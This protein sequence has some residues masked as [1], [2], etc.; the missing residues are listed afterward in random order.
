LS[1]IAVIYTTFLRDDLAK[2]TLKSILNNWNSDYKL[3][4]G[5]QSGGKSNGELFRYF[6]DYLQKNKK[7]KCVSYY[8]LPF[9]CG[10]S[11]ARNF[12]VKK[13]QELGC[14]YCLVTADSI[15]FTKKY[16]FDSIIKFMELKEGIV[17]VGF[18]L[19]NRVPWEFNMR[20]LPGECF[21][22]RLSSEKFLK[23]LGIEYQ[24]VDICKNFFLAKTQLLLNIP[25]DNEL[26]L[27]EH[28]DH[29]WRLKQVGYKTYVTNSINAEYIDDKPLEYKQYRNR[30]YLEYR[31]K[32]QQKYDI[33][34]WVKR[35]F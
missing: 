19:K 12:L 14:G 17:K 23:Y 1:K 10:L 26:S 35:I 4:I 32:L 29:C 3:L 25:W 11:Y 30:M 31:K 7:R 2:K 22:L 18:S 5:D 28:E 24:K 34:G 21:E 6:V 13:A 16:K 9:D 15:K 27:L 20:L 33:K 8:Q